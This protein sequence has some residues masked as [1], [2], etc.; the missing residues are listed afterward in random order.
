MRRHALASA[1]VRVRRPLR[2]RPED[3]HLDLTLRP[4]SDGVGAGAQRC[5]AEA[6]PSAGH[7]LPR[8][9]TC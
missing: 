4:A 7:W 5:W 3:A 6:K 2:A 1:S 8:L 9:S